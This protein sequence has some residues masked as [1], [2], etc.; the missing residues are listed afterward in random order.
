MGGNELE[1]MEVEQGADAEIVSS[2]EARFRFHGHGERDALVRVLQEHLSLVDHAEPGIRRQALASLASHLDLTRELTTREEILHTLKILLWKEEESFL[3]QSLVKVL[4]D[5]ALVPLCQAKSPR[6]VIA[7]SIPHPE[8]CACVERV[9]DEQQ[10]VC[11]SCGKRANPQTRDGSR[12]GLVSS[13][14]SPLKRKAHEKWISRVEG[15]VDSNISVAKSV[16]QLLH[17]YLAA[18]DLVELPLES[19]VRV[20]L[21]HS[22]LKIG[23][24]TDDIVTLESLGIAVRRHLRSSN[25]KVR[26][27][28]IRLLVESVEENLTIADNAVEIEEDNNVKRMRVGNE[29]V[30]VPAV[31]SVEVEMKSADQ[32]KVGEILMSSVLNYIKDPYPSVRETALRGLMK[33]HAKGYE[34]TSECCK[35]AT[36]LFRDSFE[37]VRI[38]AIEMVS[39]VSSF[40][41]MSG[42][43][44]FS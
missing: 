25:P 6:A 18:K 38:A 42:V 1:A 21:L 11:E 40:S 2:V 17:A 15:C 19:T 27:L 23:E 13:T 44:H 16:A 5:V 9:S 43:S 37:Y 10:G 29:G 34:L 32:L 28:V 14:T 26:A 8:L 41:L 39:F 4:V 24:K 36:S 22:L 3:V 33:L 30:Q 7:G 12:D 31:G 20:Q 35:M